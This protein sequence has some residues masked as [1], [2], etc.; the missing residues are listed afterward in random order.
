M[1]SDEASREACKT[2]E[3]ILKYMGD[4]PVAKSKSITEFTDEIFGAALENELL[5][6]EV[7]C[8]IIRQLTYNRL[9]R[10]EN[11]GWEL[12]YLAT[13]LFVPSAGLLGE[14]QSFLKSRTQQPL[15]ESCLQRLH[16]TQKVTDY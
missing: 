8:Q 13:G 14:L 16:K 7:Y 12:L 1:S 4:L 6:D 2:F 11:S 10:S 3:A 15:V 9:I 5:K